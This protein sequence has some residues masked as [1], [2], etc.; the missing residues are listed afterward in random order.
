MIKE[1]MNIY[2]CSVN[3]FLRITL[4]AFWLLLGATACIASPSA[5][6]PPPSSMPTTEPTRQ[7]IVT[8]TPAHTN[9]PT[10]VYTLAPTATETQAPTPT[11]P[12]LA[13]PGTPL[14]AP[15]API[16][17]ENAAQVSGLAEWQSQPVVDIA[18]TAG[19]QVLAVANSSA[20]DLY[21]LTTR[22]KIRS[23]YPKAEGIVDIAFSPSGTWLVSGSRRGSEQG[24]FFSTLELWSG[25][26]W[27]PLG[28]MYDAPV[29]LSDMDF[30]PDGLILVAAFAS[31]VYEQNS[32]VF[33]SVTSW[34][35]NNALE[36]GAA[37]QVAISLD[38]TMLA[39]TPDRY[40]I[41]IW[42]LLEWQWLYNIPTSFTG[43]VQEIAFSPDKVSLATGHYDGEIRLW[44]MLTGDLVFTMVAEEVI[45]SLAFSPDGRLL[46]TGGSYQNQLIRLWDMQTG[47]LLHS[48]PGH[49]HAVEYLAFSPNGAYLASASYDGMVR[50]WGIRP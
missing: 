22:E 2:S 33:F 48:M 37:L 49:I 23:L 14:P 44:D 40:A 50:I 13:L 9:T 45:E 4:C 27:K 20:I 25:P 7:M 17:A 38:N 15:Q 6:P 31:P 1:T 5:V 41:R 8:S 19:G 18:W 39:L 32:V 43:A 35:I 36:T 26:D 28:I 10:A 34:T 29:A 42:D 30:S 3:T 21:D 12:L 47:E 16:L 11:T 46:A 24:G